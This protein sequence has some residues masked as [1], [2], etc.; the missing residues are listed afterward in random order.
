MFEQQNESMLTLHEDAFYEFFRPYRHPHSQHD[1][2]GGL[3]LETFGT[4]LELVKQLPATHVRTVIDWRCHRRPM[5]SNRHPYG[6][7]YLLS[8]YGSAARLEGH[9]VPH[10]VRDYSLTRLGLL[11]QMNKIARLL[12]GN[13]AFIS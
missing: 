5:D 12:S 6:E 4:D 9:P 8:G 11:R 3:G 2:W 10:P 7:S 13:Q 1:I